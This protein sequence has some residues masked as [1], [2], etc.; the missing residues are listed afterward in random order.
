[1]SNWF[2]RVTRNVRMFVVGFFY[3]MKG[4]DT[5]MMS[6][7]SSDGEEVTKKIE[8]GG[9]VYQEMLNEQET[10][11]VKETRDANYRVYREAD[12]YDV[13]VTG[14]GVDDDNEELRASAT[15]KI[16]HDKPRTAVYETKWYKPIIVQDARIFEND[17]TVKAQEAETGEQIK[18]D[19]TNIFSVKYPDGEF[20]RHKI[21]NYLQRVVVRQSK[22]SAQTRVDL[23]FSI[24]AR[25]FWKQDSLFIAE[26][27]RIFKLNTKHSDILD[28]E[29]LSFVTNKAFGIDDLYKI[30]LTNLVYRETNIFDG[31]FVLEFECQ[32]NKED[33]TE[34]YRTKELDE[35]YEKQAPKHDGIAIDVLMR[36]IN[37]D[38]PQEIEQNYEP[39]TF[40]LKKDDNSN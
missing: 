5:T 11:Q 23:Y 2:K 36:H 14:M 6:P 37:G 8:K 35:K 24:Y 10:Q 33:L 31:N 17:T 34:K 38:K 27:N 30:T 29:E 3:G 18:D 15:K 22:K 40:K 21:E 12:K 13:N 1:M 26:L 32:F 4:A 39:T 25:Q 20:P 9:N 7:V 28:I 16:G 19:S